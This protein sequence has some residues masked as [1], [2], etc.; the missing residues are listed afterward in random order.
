M[1]HGGSDPGAFKLD[2]LNPVKLIFYQT[3]ST[4]LPISPKQTISHYPRERKDEWCRGRK[5]GG[6]YQKSL[7]LIHFL[8]VLLSPLSASPPSSLWGNKKW[9]I[10]GR[11]VKGWKNLEQN[12]LERLQ[13]VRFGIPRVRNP[14]FSFTFG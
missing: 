14:C 2:H 10:M 8:M 3:F 9:F 1:Q 7:C 12:Q 6:L 5:W 4:F 13:M 11:W